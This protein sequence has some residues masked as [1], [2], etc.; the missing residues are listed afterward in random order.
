MAADLEKALH[1]KVTTTA[2]VIAV[3]ATRFYPLALPPSVTL[4]AA[5]YQSIPAGTLRKIHNSKGL[6]PRQRIQIT[7][8]GTT[9]AAVVSVDRVIR[10][11]IDGQRGSWGTGSFITVVQG[12]QAETTPYDDKDAE[13]G[14]F[15]RIRDYFI[16]WSE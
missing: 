4:P 16:M 12:C 1:H 15:Y 13:T 10:D 7:A 6:L 9:F 3:I 11:A 8:W 5:V 2:G 14:L